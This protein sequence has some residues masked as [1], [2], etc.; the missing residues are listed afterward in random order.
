M[1]R[2]PPVLQLSLTRTKYE[3]VTWQRLKVNDRFE[4]PLEIDMSKYMS[5][6]EEGKR[7]L[8]DPDLVNYD[9]K[10]IIIHEGGPYGGHYYC[11][12]K[13]D[14][15]EGN[16]NLQVPKKSAVKPLEIEKN[17]EEKKHE[18]EEVKHKS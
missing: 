12:L 17:G 16:W 8:A 4:F 5:D 11:F 14:L 2:C 3:E 10:A 13:D 18:S 1:S 6:C 9:L 15:K 7:Q